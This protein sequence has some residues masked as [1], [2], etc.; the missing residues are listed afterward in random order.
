MLRNFS[1][2]VS[3][4]CQRR[5]QRSIEAGMGLLARH[6]PLEYSKKSVQGSAFLSMSPTWI[7]C[8]FCAAREA[9]A[10]TALNTTHRKR[11]ALLR[12]VRLQPSAIVLSQAITEKSLGVK[13]G[14]V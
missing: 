6:A 12:R 5:L 10:R 3:P 13:C 1:L 2:L 14:E 8:W 9:Q 7:P 11:I 4:A